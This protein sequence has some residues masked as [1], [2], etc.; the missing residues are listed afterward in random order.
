MIN[1]HVWEICVNNGLRKW[2]S[3]ERGVCAVQ[4]VWLD[5]YKLYTCTLCKLEFFFAS[6]SS[7]FML[8]NFCE[9]AVWQ[10]KYFM[11]MNFSYISILPDRYSH[12]HIMV[13]ESLTL[14]SWKVRSLVRASKNF[15]V[16]W[17]FLGQN[18]LHFTLPLLIEP[19]DH[20]FQ[21]NLQEFV[22]FSIQDCW[23][24]CSLWT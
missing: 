9:Y 5:M 21:A 7:N 6:K 1:I 3:Y 14:Q 19:S 17:R 18:Q 8:Q 15:C 22:I 24:Y 12:R 13:S 10:H 11:K 2:S 4:L 20:C 16:I 23:N